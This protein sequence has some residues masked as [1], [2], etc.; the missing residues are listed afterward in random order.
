MDSSL[1]N[2]VNSLVSPSGHKRRL[3][4]LKPQNKSNFQEE[5]RLKTQSHS[6]PI[7][8]QKHI[9]KEVESELYLNKGRSGY[10]VDSLWKIDI[11]I[12]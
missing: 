12:S 5:I 2:K 11:P 3:N 4:S 1:P 8:P 7:T 6:Q 9:P 10:I